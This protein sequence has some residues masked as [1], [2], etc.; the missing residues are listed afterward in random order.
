MPAQKITKEKYCQAEIE[1]AMKLKRLN[2]EKLGKRLGVSQGAV[3][4]YVKN[5]YKVKPVVILMM[6]DILG[7]SIFDIMTRYWKEE[8]V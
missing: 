8:K 5:I 3:C 7:I 4:G 6:S 2:Q 1:S